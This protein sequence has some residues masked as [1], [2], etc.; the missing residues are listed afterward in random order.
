MKI[1]FIIALIGVCGGRDAAV[2]V[3]SWGTVKVPSYPV[4]I[5]YPEE[6]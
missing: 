3:T 6:E 5:E 1:Y 2:G 4:S